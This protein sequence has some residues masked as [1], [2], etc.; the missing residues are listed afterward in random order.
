MLMNVLKPFFQCA[1]L[2]Q[3]PGKAIT[4][5]ICLL[6]KRFTFQTVCDKDFLGCVIGDIIDSFQV[7]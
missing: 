1:K 2:H 3:L 5:R 7:K 6:S 4:Y